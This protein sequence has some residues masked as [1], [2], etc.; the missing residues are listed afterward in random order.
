[1]N[2]GT[3]TFPC[4]DCLSILSERNPAGSHKPSSAAL[5][6]LQVEQLRSNGTGGISVTKPLSPQTFLP[7]LCALN[8]RVCRL[9][10]I[11]MC[12]K[13][14]L[15]HFSPLVKNSAVLFLNISTSW[16]SNPWLP[17]T[18]VSSFLKQSSSELSQL[19]VMDSYLHISTASWYLGTK[20]A[21]LKPGL[22]AFVIQGR[23][24]FMCGDDGE[25]VSKTPAQKQH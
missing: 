19:G 13:Q 24:H 22:L 17:H 20:M 16:N 2:H 7:L 25:Q 14:H 6:S 8:Y 12:V 23:T 1:M 21:S 15:Q 18:S 3:I 4:S 10:D 5:L 11:Y 9:L